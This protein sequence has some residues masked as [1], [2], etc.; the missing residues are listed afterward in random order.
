[1]KPEL[2]RSQPVQ[3]PQGRR[4]LRRIAVRITR[5]AWLGLLLIFG[6]LLDTYCFDVSRLKRESEVD[7]QHAPGQESRPAAAP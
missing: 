6:F 2:P 7:R 3:H 1:M 4:E 5:E